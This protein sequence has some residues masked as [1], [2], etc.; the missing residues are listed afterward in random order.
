MSAYQ[1]AGLVLWF[2]CLSV[3]GLSVCCSAGL[4]V[5][6]SVGQ[7]FSLSACLSGSLGRPTSAVE[8]DSDI[9]Q[10]LS[11]PESKVYQKCRPKMPKTFRH[12]K[13]VR[14][15]VITHYTCKLCSVCQMSSFTDVLRETHITISLVELCSINLQGRKMRRIS[16]NA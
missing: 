16:S 4:L 5:C 14:V 9:S 8:S 11:N 12:Q 7:L 15:L 10:M 3:G 2:V 13:I 1:P 6:K